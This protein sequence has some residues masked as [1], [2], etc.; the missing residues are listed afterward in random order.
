MDGS[1]SLILLGIRIAVKD[2][3]YCSAAEMVFG[4]PLKIP[5]QGKKTFTVLQN[6]KESVVSIDRV[7]PAYLEKLATEDASPCFIQILQS[8]KQEN[9]H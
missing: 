5:D 4:V 9:K 7:K 2:D 8:R 6:G 1:S 3:L